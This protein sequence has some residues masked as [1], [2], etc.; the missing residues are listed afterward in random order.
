MK[1]KGLPQKDQTNV[2]RN[3]L[4]ISSASWH[5]QFFCSAWQRE[6]T[7]RREL[8]TNEAPSPKKE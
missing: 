3:L 1:I 5:E 7:S 4:W 2:H 6:L 8:S